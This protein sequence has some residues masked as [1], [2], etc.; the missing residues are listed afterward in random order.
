VDLARTKITAFAVSSFL[1][2][3]S[4]ALLAQFLGHLEPQGFTMTESVTLV[5]AVVVGGLASISGSLL[6]AAFVVLVPALGSG[7]AGFV[8]VTYGLGLLLVLSFQPEGLA[9]L[10][11][12]LRSAR[13]GGSSGPSIP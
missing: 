11:R 4:G 3:A 1:T 7:T 12:R 13:R 10:F 2:G 8:P 9:G 6:G 5:V